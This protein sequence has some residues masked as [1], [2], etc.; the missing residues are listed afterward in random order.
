[1][2]DYKKLEEVHKLAE[3]LAAKDKCDVTIGIHFDMFLNRECYYLSRF[4]HGEAPLYQNI[5]N[6]IGA[7]EELTKPEQKYNVGDLVWHLDDEDQVCSFVVSKFDIDRNQIYYKSDSLTDSWWLEEQLYPSKLGL[8]E[9][10]VEHWECLLKEEISTQCEK[11][12]MQPAFEGEIKGFTRCE[13]EIKD[14][15]AHE[16]DYCFYYS[17]D[18]I[19]RLARNN[20]VHL[21]GAFQ[22]FKCCKCGEFY[23]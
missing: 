10:Q 11:V 9:S 22:Y 15:C 18:D 4:G 16:S 5:D 7:L 12:S 23:K 14:N 1:M 21:Y 19:S 2:I 3:K 20:Y 8:L 13:H 6:L 17:M